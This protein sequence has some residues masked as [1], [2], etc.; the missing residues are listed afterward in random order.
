MAAF[1]ISEIVEETLSHW[2]KNSESKNL[3]APLNDP[4]SSPTC[5]AKNGTTYLALGS[6]PAA[7]PLIS[8]ASALSNATDRAALVASSKPSVSFTNVL[9]WLN[10]FITSRNLSGSV[11]SASACASLLHGT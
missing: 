4:D 2:S 10:V 5:F 3:L 9:Y 1:A 8:A 7:T 6:S 11:A